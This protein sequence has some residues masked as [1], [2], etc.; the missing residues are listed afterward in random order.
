[1]TES[2]TQECCDKV[3]CVPT[4]KWRPP[5]RR[6]KGCK[7]NDR[8]YDIGEPMPSDDPCEVDWWVLEYIVTAHTLLACL[9]HLLHDQLNIPLGKRFYYTIATI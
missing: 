7:A 1:M 3:K 9:S 2:D 4:Q 5:W 8:T 6:K